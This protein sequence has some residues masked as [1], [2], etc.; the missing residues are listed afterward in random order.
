MPRMHQPNGGT[1]GFPLEAV[2]RLDQGLLLHVESHD[3]PARPDRSGQERGVVSVAD[4]G[5]DRNPALSDRPAGE[6]VR[7]LQ[8]RRNHHVDGIRAVAGQRVRL[9][10][11]RGRSGNARP[12]SSNSERA[13]NLTPRQ[14]VRQRKTYAE[15]TRPHG[16]FR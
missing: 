10:R 1:E 12:N 4:R 2:S 14:S 3:G 6:G 8:D 15:P 11:G 5:V 9:I 13:R 7:L 16:R